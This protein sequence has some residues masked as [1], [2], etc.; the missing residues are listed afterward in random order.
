MG[1]QHVVQADLGG[2][3]I[4]STVLGLRFLLVRISAHQRSFDSEIK[5]WMIH[6]RLAAFLL[7]PLLFACD[8]DTPHVGS[9]EPRVVANATPAWE[10]GR[11]WRLGPAPSVTIGESEG[12]AEYQLDHVTG[13]LV[14]SDTLIVIGDRGAGQI[15]YFSRRGTHLR[16]VGRNGNGPGEFRSIGWIGA[17]G[18]S[19][20]VWDVFAARLTVLKPDGSLARAVRFA[21]PDGR[22]YLCAGILGDGSL[23]LREPDEKPAPNGE[24]VDSITYV[25]VSTADG[26][27]LGRLGPVLLGERFT[28]SDGRNTLTGWVTF[29]KRG[30]VV[31]APQGLLIGA[32]APFRLTLQ[33]IDGKP[34]RSFGRPWRPQRSSKTEWDAARGQEERTGT[35]PQFN[36]PRWAV[37]ERDFYARLPHRDTLPAFTRALVDGAGNVWMEEFRID[38]DAAGTW[39]VFDHDGRW[40][41]QVQTPAGVTVMS[42]SRDAVVGVTRDEMDVE[43][44]VVYP[45]LR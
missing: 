36:N 33:G 7:L 24:H 39:S 40:L 15:R 38:P 3:F 35:V 28:A 16:T 21:E 44:V 26:A 18:D 12:G 9:G 20:V 25:R 6:P 5:Q 22:L 2:L 23:L 8:R 27:V 34:V 10:D 37:L 4:G 43:R 1:C 31:A 29:G 14:V 17:H 11:G 32:T 19:V 30:V 42:I 41:G 45:L 13:A